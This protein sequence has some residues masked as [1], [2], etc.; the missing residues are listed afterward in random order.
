MP[1]PAI[2]AEI[3]VCLGINSWYLLSECSNVTKLFG[4]DHYEPYQEWDRPIGKSEQLRNL[5]TLRANLPMLGDRFHFLHSDSQ[6]A[7]E[8]IDDDHLDF[9]FIDGGHSMRQVLRDLDSWVPKV[10]QGGLIA[11][12]DSNLF[13]VNFAVTSW[14]KNKKVPEADLKMARNNCWYWIKD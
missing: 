11:G 5:S 8:V 14:C 1:Y 3:G 7:A 13:S 12:H 4:I 2:G 6:L 9:V 10:R